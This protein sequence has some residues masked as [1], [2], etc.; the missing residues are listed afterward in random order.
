MGKKLP[1]LLLL[2]IFTS[3]QAVYSQSVEADVTE[4]KANLEYLSS[5]ELMGRGT[6][7]EGERLASEFIAEKFRQYGVKP[8]GDNG[9]YFQNF[10]LVLTSFTE[11]SKIKI[12]SDGKETVYNVKDDF[13]IDARRVSDEKFQRTKNEIVFAG[14]GITA[15]EF[16]YDDY[17]G[18]DVKGKTVLI[19][20]DE[21]LSDD[22]LF[23]RGVRPT[24][25]SFW[26]T[27]ARI[28][29][30]NGAAG[31]IVIAPEGTVKEWQR[32][33]E[34]TSTPGLR[35]PESEDAANPRI[36]VICI[37][38]EVAKIILNGEEKTYDE[39]DALFK[40]SSPI[41]GFELSKEMEF[42]LVVKEEEQFSRNV[43]GIIEGTDPLL[44]N[45][46]VS[47]GA[48]YDHE[49]VRNGEVYNGADDNASGT[50]AVM[51]TGKLLAQNNGNKRSVIL[52]LYSA[53]ERG[54]FGSRYTAENSSYIK[55]MI[56]NINLDMVGRM[57]E[58]TLVSIGSRRLSSELG[59]IVEDVNSR[60]SKFVFDYTFDDPNDPNRLYERSDH[61][62]FAKQG[63]P[64]VFFTDNMS[65]D[66][67][68]PTDDAHKINYLN[69][70]RY[71]KWCMT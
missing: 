47:I 28:A 16:G 53:E 57:S 33:S 8:F 29:R 12:F 46:Y 43:I 37:L 55:D 35:Y 67:H 31:V 56:V 34:W 68:K 61:Y 26:G 50:V 13:I 32:L 30:D 19:L 41:S 20:D 15:P 63:I 23:F 5:D 52:M 64:V 49:G 3:F 66:Y 60:T 70:E 10:P 11:D 21:P 25:Y 2:L 62:N 44:K 38:P 6:L 4:L 45:E 71:V 40:E 1:V 9:T 17:K 7:T 24:R 48:H 18:L 51:E 39:I 22:T 42:S 14:F 58:D 27:K 59:N 54:L 36:P 65:E 69:L